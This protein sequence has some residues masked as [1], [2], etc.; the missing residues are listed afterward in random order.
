MN[1]ELSAEYIRA[2]EL[3]VRIKTSAQLAQKSLYDMCI[4]FKEMRDSKLYKELGYSDF[5]D[6]CENETGMK[7]RSVYNYI[8]I[9]EKLPK[10][11][12]QPLHKT[13]T[14]KL[15]LIAKL[16]EEERTELTDK[17]DIESISVKELKA[18]IDKL[19]DENKK[20]AENAESRIKALQTRLDDT[21]NAMRKATAEANGLAEKNSELERQIKEL[22]SR[23]IE[24]V[25]SPVNDETEKMRQAMLQN[26]REWGE[27]YDKLQEENEK[28]ERS[29]HQKY[30]TALSEQKA[31]YEKKLA[32]AKTNEQSGES[33]EITVFK[34]YFTMAY[35][36]FQNLVQFAQQAKDKALMQ[37][38]IRKL[39]DT[40]MQS[41][42][43]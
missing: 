28:S 19:K 17:T 36:A 31:E 18:E 32:E 27:K 22:E 25:A 37:E 6:Y 29:L 8:T 20:T 43:G 42:E 26:S 10:D 33:D 3:D 13:Q 39:T 16:S 34:A 40:V 35:Q 9:A 4:S 7:R 11:F 14:R 12:V 21:G 23:P 41:M 5:G 15:L 30:Q 38:K 24:V 1:N 2:H